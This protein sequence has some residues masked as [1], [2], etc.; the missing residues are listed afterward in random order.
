MNFVIKKDILLEN[1]IITSK[2]LSNKN[3]IPVLSG[4]KFELTKNGLYLVASDN[5]IIIQTFISKENIEEIKEL[6][7]IV[8]P[9]K[10]IVEIIKK[11]PSN[12]IN[13]NKIDGMKISVLF[14]KGEFNINGMDSN[15]FPKL[16][17]EETKNPIYLKSEKFKEIINETVFAISTSESRPILTGLNFKINNNLL[18]CYATD[19]YRLA[20]KSIEIKSNINNI[21]IVIPGKNIIE[22]K[23][24][25]DDK[26]KEIELHIFENKI[27]LKKDNILFQSKLIN[28]NYPDVSKLIPNEF[29]INLKINTFDF[30]NVIDRAS[31]LSNDKDKVIIKLDLN[32]NKINISSNTPE[33]GKVEEYIEVNNSDSIIISFISKYMLEALKSYNSKNIILCFNEED[34]PFII[35]DENEN[36]LI[37]LILPIKTY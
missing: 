3:L 25:I 15:E 33:L 31:L 1:L 36:L 35:K 19:S 24:I 23:N 20:K 26:D 29:K 28:G 7:S 21:N 34:K 37:Q 8:I 30:Y 22:F 11:T 10:Y 12:I 5:D 32:N 9:G 6:G 14:D 18:E 27:L 17:L 16:E 13:I 4:I 2:A